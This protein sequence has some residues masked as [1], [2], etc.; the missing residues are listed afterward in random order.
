MLR[1]YLHSIGVAI[2]S[3]VAGDWDYYTLSLC[4]YDKDLNET[5]RINFNNFKTPFGWQFCGYEY[6]DKYAMR[7]L[8]K[9]NFKLVSKFF[10]KEQLIE[11]MR[12]I[13]VDNAIL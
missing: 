9:H 1:D 13:I 2:Q 5:N 10:T 8:L 4:K 6:R 11:I 7:R 3:E 12:I